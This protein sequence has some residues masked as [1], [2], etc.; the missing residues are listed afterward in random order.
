MRA[1]PVLF[2]SEIRDR[3]EGIVIYSFYT[4]FPSLH[5]LT[6]VNIFL[7]IVSSKTAITH[8]FQSAVRNWP[9]SISRREIK[10][11]NP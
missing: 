4:W 7:E 2:T 10:V 9:A 3:K 8:I 5:G 1:F 6:R 11:F